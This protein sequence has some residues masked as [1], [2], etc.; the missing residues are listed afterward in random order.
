MNKTVI[1]NDASAKSDKHYRVYI[2]DMGQFRDPKQYEFIAEFATEEL[3]AYYMR[4]MRDKKRYS[5]KDIIIRETAASK[6]SERDEKSIIA[7]S[8][9]GEY[10]LPEEWN[11]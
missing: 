6:L 9:L 4:Y 7:C 3:A 11:F 8:V 5:K 2:A 10:L 1:V